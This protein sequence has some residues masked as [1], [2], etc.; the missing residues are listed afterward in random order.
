MF[1]LLAGLNGILFYSTQC[2]GEYL[3]SKN[4]WGEQSSI[5][6][7]DYI[8]QKQI[9]NKLPDDQEEAL[10]TVDAIIAYYEKVKNKKPTYY[11]STN[12]E[13]EMEEEK[14]LEE[15]IAAG[16]VENLDIENYKRVQKCLQNAIG[17]KDY[18]QGI[19]ANAEAIAK[20][21]QPIYADK[22]LL[23]NIAR[24]KQ[25]YYGMDYVHLWVTPDDV[26]KVV[27]GY[28]VTD[29]LA[30]LF[31]GMYVI[32]LF[33]YIKTD[34][35]GEQRDFRKTIM[36]A[37]VVLCGSTVAFY[38]INFLIAGQ[39]FGSLQQFISIQ[40]L[41][42]FYT[43]PV[44][45]TVG[46]FFLI[47]IGM[48]MLTLLL[49]LGIFLLAATGRRKLLFCSLA[50]AFVLFEFWQ[51]MTPAQ[52][53]LETFLTEINLFSGITAERFFN[54]YLNLTI[55]TMVVPRIPFFFVLFF[56]AVLVVGF[57]VYKRIGRWR[58]SYREAA[59]NVYFGEIEKRYQETRMLWHDFHNHLLAIQTLYENGQKE[60]AEKYIDE[61]SEQTHDRLLPAKT[62]SNALNLLLYK[63]Q[64]Q[65]NK[66]G[67]TIRFGIGCSI[68]GMAIAEYD[69][70]SLFGNILDNATEAVRRVREEK[71]VISLSVKQQNN[72]L[73]ILCENPYE[74]EIKKQDGEIKTT[75][76]DAAKHGIGLA[77]IRHICR[78]YD[79]R[80]E[81]ETQDQKFCLSVL[82]NI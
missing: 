42:E 49:F 73:F 1:L 38:M 54:R 13:N 21:L 64:E 66:Y 5:K 10:E 6:A 35:F 18:I 24:C 33:Y 71:P 51:Y 59:M 32:A 31:F 48:K 76:K 74:G 62:G 44:I 37:L 26:V 12:Q 77:S 45:M 29:L 63:K 11:S 50:A 9:I 81:I 79:G 8:K 27:L 53:N 28:H 56:A 61:L 30:L 68:E 17:Y 19:G 20:S 22:L 3:Q 23:K 82:L 75:K 39:V 72:M 15:Y 40:S 16:G 78:K 60:Q 69:L 67:I 55:G 57:F 7:K 14:R 52:G 43:C 70:C 2:S 46:Q 58:K 41:E 47:Y 25:D 34:P 4:V 65:A 80:M 36:G